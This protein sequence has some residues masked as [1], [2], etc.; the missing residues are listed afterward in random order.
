MLK[1]IL[2]TC[3]LSFSV[4]P[5]LKAQNCGNDEIYHLPYKIGRASCR[6]RV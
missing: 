5:L 1:H 3:L 2:F 4:T 6:E